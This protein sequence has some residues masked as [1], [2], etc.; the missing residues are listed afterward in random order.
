MVARRVAC[1]VLVA[2]LL[3]VGCAK[4]AKVVS[5]KGRLTKGDKPCEGVGINFVSDDPM[6]QSFIGSTTPDGSFEM[7]SFHGKPGVIPAA[8]SVRINIPIDAPGGGLV[9]AKLVANDSPWRVTI[10]DKGNDNLQLDLDKDLI[11]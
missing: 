10:T 8:Y 4:A 6:G 5:V 7:Y 2:C 11:E 3:A 1:L 9:P